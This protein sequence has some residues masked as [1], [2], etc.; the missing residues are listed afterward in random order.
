[1]TAA[2]ERSDS[3]VMPNAAVI[4]GAA[5]CS[6]DFVDKPTVSS[7]RQWWWSVGSKVWVEVVPHEPEFVWTSDGWC[8]FGNF[9]GLW[10]G[11]WQPPSPPNEKLSESARENQ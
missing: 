1:M 10:Y 4:A 9:R 6:A 2:P 7:I 8:H 11:P 5:H 3:T